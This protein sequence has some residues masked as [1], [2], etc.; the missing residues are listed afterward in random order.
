MTHRL[1]VVLSFDVPEPDDIA[2]VLTA[3]NPPS[4]PHFAGQARI[5]VE[6]VSR[7]VETWLDDGRLPPRDAP[8][9]GPIS[10]ADADPHRP[11]N[12]AE[13]RHGHR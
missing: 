7:Q 2:E 1:I 3:I 6:P 9:P 4:L 5:S 13:R 8:F 12:R 10:K 11:R